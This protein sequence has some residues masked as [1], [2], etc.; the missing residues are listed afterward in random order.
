M[1]PARGHGMNEPTSR[2]APYQPGQTALLLVDMQRIW[3]E[4]GLGTTHA[5]WN[6]QDYFYR[7]TATRVIPNQV[8]LLTAAR[9]AGIDVKPPPV[10]RP[11]PKDPVPSPRHHSHP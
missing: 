9:R 5:K 2:D 1:Q 3:L 11:P 7:E 10:R 6:P 4:P 8:E